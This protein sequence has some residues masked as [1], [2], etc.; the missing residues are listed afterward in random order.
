MLRITDMDAHCSVDD[1][2]DLCAEALAADPDTAVPDDAVPFEPWA[3][4]SGSGALPGWYMPAPDRAARAPRLA[5][6]RGAVQQRHAGVSRS[7]PSPPPGSATPTE[8]STS[9]PCTSDRHGFGTPGVRNARCSPTAN[10]SADTLG[11]SSA[12]T[13]RYRCAT[14]SEQSWSRPR[15]RSAGSPWPARR[16][17]PSPRPRTSRTRVTC[18]RSWSLPACARSA[19][20][21]FGAQGGANSA[22]NSLGGSIPGIGGE[23]EATISVTPGETLTVIVGGQGGPGVNGFGP[24]DGGFGGGGDGGNS[25]G[26]NGTNPGSGG[27]GASAVVRST[28]PL[29]VA[30]GGGGAGNSGTAG[31]ANGGAG[32]GTEAARHRQPRRREH[33]DRWHRWHAGSGRRTRDRQRWQHR[34]RQRA[35]SARVAR[36]AKA[37]RAAVAAAAAAGSA[38]AAVA[39]RCQ[40]RRVGRRRWWLRL[41]RLRDRHVDRRRERRRRLGLRSP[42]SP[43]RRHAP[44]QY[45]GGPTPRGPTLHRLTH[46]ERG[47]SLPP[48]TS[49]RRW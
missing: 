47:R 21:A 17:P 22:T 32:G 5:P 38:A 49:G 30:G 27:G 36:A 39:C 33:L 48:L 18:S 15:P 28:E 6:A 35:P 12:R 40:Q 24:G 10:P 7:S 26:L 34:P 23:A 43:V 3:A 45:A 29:V 1:D 16:R 31:E 11:A 2:A 19:S 46:Y 4:A 42:T 13:G 25:S 8:T 37:A 14:E 41:P 20:I 9:E 44:R